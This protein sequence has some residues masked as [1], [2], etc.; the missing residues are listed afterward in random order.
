MLNEEFEALLTDVLKKMDMNKKI[1]DKTERLL[2]ALNVDYPNASLNRIKK[3]I[4]ILD[5]QSCKKKKN[6]AELEQSQRSLIQFF[7]QPTTTK[8]EEIYVYVLKCEMGKYYVGQTT[9]IAQQF[10]QHK[11]GFGAAWTAFNPP[12]SL[13]ECNAA[14]DFATNP[15]EAVLIQTKKYMLEYGIEN[16][17]GSKYSQLILSEAQKKRLRHSLASLNALTFE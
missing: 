17:R 12:I 3:K 4:D 15:K 16:V 5:I 1:S 6:E 10:I 9:D 8:E 11:H 2:L 13:I 14:S 7:E